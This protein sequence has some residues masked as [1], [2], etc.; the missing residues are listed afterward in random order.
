MSFS[1]PLRARRAIP[2]LLSGL[3]LLTLT[4]YAR[5]QGNGRTAARHFERVIIVVLENQGIQSAMKDPYVQELTKQAAWFASYEAI[6]HPSFPNYL[7]LVAGT[8]FGIEHDHVD[9]PLEGPNIADRLE[10]R[11]LT[12]KSYAE[13][14]PGNCFLHHGA[15]EAR[16][17]PKGPPTELYALKHVP[18]LAF[19]NIQGNKKRCAKVVSDREFWRDVNAGRLPHYAFYTPNTFNDGHDT[20]LGYSTNWLRGFIDRLKASSDLRG[21]L[22]VVTWDEGGPGDHGGNQVLTMLL[23][24]VINPG[25]YNDDVTHYSLLRSIENNFGLEPMHAGDREAKSL[26]DKV[27]RH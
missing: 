17:T 11:G 16:L 10:E 14:Y 12:W 19:A 18:L 23:G 15:G 25:R 27:W 22:I 3:L 2:Y 4:F 20:S 8:T 7:A 24:P 1:P 13:D 5:A 21:T 26:P 9:H 6:T